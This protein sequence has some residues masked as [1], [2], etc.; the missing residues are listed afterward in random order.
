MKGE[1]GTV[2]E[3]ARGYP[4]PPSTMLLDKTGGGLVALLAK[5][6][7]TIERELERNIACVGRSPEGVPTKSWHKPMEGLSA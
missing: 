1:S 6:R 3:F 4:S 7:A 2:G 5:G